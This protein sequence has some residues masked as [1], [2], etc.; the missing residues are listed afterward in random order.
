[1]TSWR[2]LRSATASPSSPGGPAP[3]RPST[4]SGSNGLATS[5]TSTTRRAS[6]AFMTPSGTIYGT[7]SCARATPMTARENQL[8]AS[9]IARSIA[10]RR[11]DS[12]RLLALQAA[13][14]VVFLLFWWAASGRLVDRLFA[15][16]PLSV[17]RAFGRIVADGSLS[18][19]LPFTLMEMVLGLLIGNVLGIATAVVVAMLPGG[20]PIVRPVM[21]A[22]WATPKTA[23]APLIVI[24]FGIDLL[25]KVVLAGSIVYLVMYF[26]T[27]SGLGSV[28]PGLVNLMRVMRAGRF[29]I[30][31]KAAL[32]SAAPYIFAALRI[33]IPGALIGAIIGEFVSSSRG[34]GYLIAFASSRYDTAKVFAGIF[35]LM[36]FALLLNAAVAAI[37]RH[38]FRWRV[39]DAARPL[40]R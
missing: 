33:A 35:S 9:E 6:P 24:W 19:H 4:R 3:S 28:D 20:E 34:I 15:S 5:S 23:I 10:E 31:A 21:L 22:L 2:L 32:P 18:W 11:R 37:E 7:R 26:N 8:Q 13:V 16:D 40:G 17:A 25:P 27:L 38:V 14:L 36:I 1:M 29:E 12:R 30:F 39:G